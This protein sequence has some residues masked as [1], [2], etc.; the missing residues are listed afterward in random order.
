M[1]RLLLEI[2]AQSFCRNS[3][4]VLENISDSDL[5]NFK[6]C[7]FKFIWFC[8]VWKLGK[9]GLLHDIERYADCIFQESDISGS[10]YAIV[11]YECD[12]VLGKKHSSLA[13]LK[14]KLNN[15]GLKVR[16]VDIFEC[17][18]TDTFQLTI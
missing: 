8:G 4:T 17:K 6:R 2:P 18:S 10:P 11:E 14:E 15:N 16:D 12:P 13:A 3:S 9:S 7:G 1:S 5:V